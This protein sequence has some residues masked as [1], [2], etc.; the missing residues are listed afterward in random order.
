MK[1]PEIVVKKRPFYKKVI[2]IFIMTATAIYCIPE[3]RRKLYSVIT[4]IMDEWGKKR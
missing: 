2:C 3:L 1:K 4:M